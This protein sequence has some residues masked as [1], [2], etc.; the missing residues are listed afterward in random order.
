MTQHSHLRFSIEPFEA[1]DIG[2]FSQPVYFSGSTFTPNTDIYSRYRLTDIRLLYQY[3]L[4]PQIANWDIKIG[5]AVSA[6]HTVIELSTTEDPPS[7]YGKAD[8]WVL[9]P[10]INAEGAYNFGSNMALIADANWISTSDDDHFDGSL[11]FNYIFDRHWDAGIGYAEYK[12]RTNT[13]ELLNS[14]KYNIVVLNVG[15]TF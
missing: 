11:M 13:S 2:Q 9:L 15:Y 14:A 3:N 4:I 10:L 1:R 8:D 6:Q 12:R 7:T 5:G